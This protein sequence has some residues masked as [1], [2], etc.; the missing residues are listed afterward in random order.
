MFLRFF[1]VGWNP[2]AFFS[3]LFPASPGRPFSSLTFGL[4]E[5]INN[6]FRATPSLLPVAHQVFFPPNLMRCKLQGPSTPPLGSRQ[7]LEG[8]I[9]PSPIPFDPLP[10]VSGMSVLLFFLCHYP[11]R[12]FLCSHLWAQCKKPNPSSLPPTTPGEVTLSF[13]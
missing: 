7:E 10:P 13:S 1:F 2:G 6:E 9:V 4:A 12:W 8:T 11:V 5:T 3:N